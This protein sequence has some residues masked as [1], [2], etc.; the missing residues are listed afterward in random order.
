MTE[1]ERLAAI[2]AKRRYQRAYMK[3]WRKE[4][5]ERVRE[6]NLKYWLRRS[7]REAKEIA[8]QEEVQD[9]EK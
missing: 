1:K 5:P 6:N 7:E 9:H 8:K 3:R 2:E 4:N